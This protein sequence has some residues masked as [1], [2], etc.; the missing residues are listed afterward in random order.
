MDVLAETFTR[1]FAARERVYTVDGSL[2]AWLY[3]MGTGLRREGVLAS[4][5]HQVRN[6]QEHGRFDDLAVVHP[7]ELGE[8]EHCDASCRQDA[9]PWSV[10]QAHEVTHL[11][12]PAA[13]ESISFV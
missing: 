3:K 4:L 8:A 13:L 9:Q 7:V 12:D 6:I 11:H 1:A 10:K 5:C 2:R